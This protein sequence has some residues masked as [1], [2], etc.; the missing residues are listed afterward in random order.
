LAVAMPLPQ[1]SSSFEASWNAWQAKGAA[2]DRAARGKLTLAAPF[3]AIVAA[4][5]FYA[6]VSR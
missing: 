6:L 4:A 3:L 2:H 5:V 1:A